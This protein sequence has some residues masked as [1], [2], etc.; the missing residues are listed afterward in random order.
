MKKVK[1]IFA[2]ILLFISAYGLEINK[3][4]VTTITSTEGKEI[5]VKKIDKGILFKEFKGKIVLLEVYGDSCPHCV[6]AIEPYNKLQKKY[7]DDI[8]IIAIE[9]YGALTN[10]N[11]QKYITIPKNGAGD[12]F[13]Y[14]KDTTG[15][16]KQ[17]VPYLMIFDK[18]GKFVYH[19]A[20]ANINKVESVIK[21]L[22]KK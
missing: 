9:T 22:L 6:R 10:L 2:A 18:D 4:D 20:V 8:V 13:K 12:I 3:K 21:T 15:Y 19:K 1:I 16:A 17:I 7:K 14:I 5:T 11:K